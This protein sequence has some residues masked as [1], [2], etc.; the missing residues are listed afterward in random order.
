VPMLTSVPFSLICARMTLFISKR[1]LTLYSFVL[2]M[3]G[4]VLPYF[5]SDFG[6]VI[7]FRALM[8][9]GLGFVNSIAPSLASDFYVPGK[10]R[11]TVMGIQG[12]STGLGGIVLSAL[13]GWLC[14]FGAKITFLS[15]LVCI[16]LGLIF[17]LT[18]EDRGKERRPEKTPHGGMGQFDP[19]A[20]KYALAAFIF[21]CSFS[22]FGLNVAY[23]IVDSGIGNTVDAGYVASVN[24]LG[25][26]LLGL[27]FGVVAG[28]LKKWSRFIGAIAAG[29]G[30]AAVGLAGTVGFAIAASFIMGAGMGLFVTSC[31]R[32]V[33]SDV[34]PEAVTMSVSLLMSMMCLAQFLSP[35]F[36]ELLMPIFGDSTVNR[37]LVSGGGMLLIGISVGI[38]NILP[39]TYRKRSAV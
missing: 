14:V 12:A 29:I 23:K 5:L 28:A 37:F 31:I 21:I 35:I 3:V 17:F 33:C 36:V 22:V 16:P 7:V 32:D 20:I 38:I 11:D 1:N 24:S 13:G 9:V 2:I 8:G 34:R 30:M 26:M 18:M 15:Y 27:M 39:K 4:G 6:S 25:N 10:K 19:K